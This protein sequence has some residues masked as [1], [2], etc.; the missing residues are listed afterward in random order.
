METTGMK[1]RRLAL[2]I[3]G[4]V[5]A[6]KSH[7]LSQL[8]L[9]HFERVEQDAELERRLRDAG[10]PLDTRRYSASQRAE[11]LRLREHVISELWTR[12]PAWREK[13]CN[14]VFETTGNKPGLF[15][16]QIEAGRAHGYTTLGCALRVPLALCLEHNRGRER[17]LAD[18][19]VEGAWT[20]F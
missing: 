1:L 13:G 5:G 7:V 2:W 14:L 16:E 18:E 19:L 8:P 4:P 6:G 15:R 11:F 20:A 17:V 3:F 10:L 9:G 12:V